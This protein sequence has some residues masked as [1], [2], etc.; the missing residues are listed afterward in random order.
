MFEEEEVYTMI[1]HNKDYSDYPDS[2][3]N[4]LV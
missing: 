1:D 3:L 2:D 4:M